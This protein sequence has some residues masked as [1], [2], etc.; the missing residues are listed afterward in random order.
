MKTTKTLA[1]LATTVAL[2]SFAFAPANAQQPNHHPE[3]TQ[4]EKTLTGAAPGMQ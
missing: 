1:A 4:A 3:T 2:T